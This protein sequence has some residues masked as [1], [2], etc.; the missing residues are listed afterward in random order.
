VVAGGWERGS[1]E[2]LLN[3]HRV[4]FWGDDNVLELDRGGGCTTL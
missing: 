4:C 1:K 2:Q 3:G